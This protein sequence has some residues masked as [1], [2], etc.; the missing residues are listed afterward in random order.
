[1]QNENGQNYKGQWK[2]NEKNGKGEYFWPNGNKYVGE[3][4]C[5][6]REGFGIMYYSN[7]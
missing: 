2:N 1:M 5:G 6:K 7:G 3:Y 4:R